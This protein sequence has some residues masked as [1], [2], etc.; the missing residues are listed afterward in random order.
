[1]SGRPITR[2]MTELLQIVEQITPELGE[3]EGEPTPLEGGITNRNYLVTLGGKRYVIRVPGKDTNLLG[4]DRSGERDANQGAAEVGIA[5]RV[6]ALLTDPPALVTEFVEGTGMEASDL[7]EPDALKQIAGELRSYHDSER[8]PSDQV[9]LL[10]PRSR[11]RRDGAQ[12]RRRA[13]PRLRGV[14]GRRRRDSGEA[15]GLRARAGPVPQRPAGRELH[16]GK[17]EDLDRRLGVRGHGRPLLR[18]R[19]LLGQQRAR[20]G[21]PGCAAGGLLRRGARRRAGSRRCRCSASCRTSARRCG[22]SCRAA[23]ATSTSTSTS[24]RPSTSTAWP[25]RRRPQV[26]DL[27]RGGRWLVRSSCPTPPAA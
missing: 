9:R 24:T 15:V 25:D 20:R 22:A 19:Q 10:H 23:S 2:E 7:Q 12:P 1:M 3:A 8:Q 18:P 13:A 4:I 5:P 16:P 17:G 6:A 27:A 11:V 14:A 26:P 21:R